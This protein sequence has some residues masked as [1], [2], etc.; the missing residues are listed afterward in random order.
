MHDVQQPRVVDVARGGTLQTKPIYGLVGEAFRMVG[1]DHFAPQDTSFSLRKHPTLGEELIV[2]SSIYQ[3]IQPI[4]R[5]VSPDT[6]LIGLASCFIQSI[7]RHSY[8]WL[9]SHVWTL[10][11]NG[12]ARGDRPTVWRRGVSAVQ[13]SLQHCP[14][15]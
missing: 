12:L 9:A 14:L 15:L 1:R 4:R 6:P 7:L 10:Y 3:R 11:P 5:L 13:I 8:A 2:L